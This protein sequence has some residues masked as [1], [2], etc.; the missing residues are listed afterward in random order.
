MCAPGCSRKRLTLVW[1]MEAVILTRLVRGI[2]SRVAWEI[3]VSILREARSAMKTRR[4]SAMN[5]FAGSAWRK[6]RGGMMKATRRWV[7][8]KRR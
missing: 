6:S 3:T 7:R 4:A 5:H 8:K 2:V 1:G